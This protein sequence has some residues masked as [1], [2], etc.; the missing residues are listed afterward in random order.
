M[1]MCKALQQKK[2]IYLTKCKNNFY[3]NKN[4]YI[5]MIHLK[6]KTYRRGLRCPLSE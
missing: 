6:T 4:K 1:K 5:K 2:I 3:I